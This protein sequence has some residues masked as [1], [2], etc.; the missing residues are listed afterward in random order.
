[1][2]LTSPEKSADAYG[3]KP[4]IIRI[5]KKNVQQANLSHTPLFVVTVMLGLISPNGCPQATGT[6]SFGC[7]IWV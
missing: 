3:A 4:Y 2:N 7:I 6:S 1:M 5:R